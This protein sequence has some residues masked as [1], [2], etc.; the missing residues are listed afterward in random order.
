M[1]LTGLKETVKKAE[2]KRREASQD[3]SL[4]ARYT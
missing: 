3:K 4:D 2:K 1:N